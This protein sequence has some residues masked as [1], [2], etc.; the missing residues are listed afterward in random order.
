MKEFAYRQDF[1]V[2]S[3]SCCEQRPQGQFSVLGN[4]PVRA[5]LPGL[6]LAPEGVS[7]RY[8][9]FLLALVFCL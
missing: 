3:C 9:P 1:A 2:M 5:P 6:S 7:G 4:E 8:R